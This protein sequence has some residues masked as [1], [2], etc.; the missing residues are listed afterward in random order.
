MKQKPD[1]SH[2][3]KAVEEELAA[4]RVAIAQEILVGDSA[5]LEDLCY[6]EGA[7]LDLV[8]M[9]SKSQTEQP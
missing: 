3:R 1:T 6:D 4:L 2:T 7:L 5:I 8:T 9:L